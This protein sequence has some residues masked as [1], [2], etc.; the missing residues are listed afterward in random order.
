MNVSQYSFHPSAFILS[1]VFT[2]LLTLRAFAPALPLALALAALQLVRPL[3]RGERPEAVLYLGEP[4][5]DDRGDDI[6]RSFVAGR[7]LVQR[8]AA[9][10][11]DDDSGLTV[12]VVHFALRE[13]AVGLAARDAATRAVV[14]REA[15]ALGPRERAQDVA[16][17][18]V[19][20]RNEHGVAGLLPHGALEERVAGGEGARRTL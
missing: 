6:L 8:H 20:P 16:P 2:R 10:S 13:R 4:R 17:V 7:G 15:A 19:A 5:A 3:E 18:L 9:V 1:V 11:V 14:D 12:L